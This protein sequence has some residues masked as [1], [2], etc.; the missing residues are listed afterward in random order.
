MNCT[1]ADGST[2]E[3]TLP[4][5]PPLDEKEG[6]LSPAF[7]R[8]FSAVAVNH[9]QEYATEAAHCY[10][11]CSQFVHGKEATTSTLPD[12]LAYSSAALASWIELALS[13]ST[14]VLYLLYARYGEELDARGMGPLAVT[15]ESNFGH[16]RDVRESLGLPVE[17][18]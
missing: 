9:A 18:G 1:G 17:E 7:I 6:V 4:G 2:T 5:L 10:R 3:R 12:V 16:L 11:R 15:I 13:A 14:S 8:E